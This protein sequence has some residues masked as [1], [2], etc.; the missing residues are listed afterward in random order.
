M[1]SFKRDETDPRTLEHDS[2]AIYT[3]G[4]TILRIDYMGGDYRKDLE[5][6]TLDLYN[7]VVRRMG[8]SR[9]IPEE[10]VSYRV[11]REEVDGQLKLIL[12][13]FPGDMIPPV[14]DKEMLKEIPTRIERV[15]ET[16]DGIEILLEELFPQDRTL[17]CSREDGT[18]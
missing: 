5:E 10:R 14:T 18:A 6:G 4:E 17:Q 8:V 1:R 15:I 2:V 9:L 12:V 16:M 11:V 7:V 13:A 3:D